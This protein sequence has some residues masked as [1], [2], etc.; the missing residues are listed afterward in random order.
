MI[1]SISSVV[2]KPRFGDQ[3]NIFGNLPYG[4]GNPVSQVAA[5]ITGASDKAGLGGV[6]PGHAGLVGFGRASELSAR[7]DHQYIAWLQP[8]HTRQELRVIRPTRD[9]TAIRAHVS[10]NRQPLTAEPTGD[11]PHIPPL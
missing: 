11:D 3:P 7:A 10:A 9:E 5:L 8:G 4:Q 2:S 6:D 1:S